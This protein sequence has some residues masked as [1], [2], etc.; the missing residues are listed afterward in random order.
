MKDPALDETIRNRYQQLLIVASKE[1]IETFLLS[2]Q[3]S[4]ASIILFD[5]F[6]RNIFR[7][8]MESFQYDPLALSI[9]LQALELNYDQQLSQN[10]K[11]FLYMPLMHSESL[12]NQDRSVELFSYDPQFQK[13]AIAHRDIVQRFGRFPHRNQILGREST[14]EEI[15]FLKQEGS[16]F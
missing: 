3:I 1:P 2:P 11:F 13:Y 6:S 9:T 14:Q 15:E 10:Q 8:Q 5:Q 7:N 12:D 16:S 4:L